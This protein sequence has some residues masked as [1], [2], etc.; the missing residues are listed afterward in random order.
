MP[1]AVAEEIALVLKSRLEAMI[2]DSS[3]YP[4]DVL[5]VIRPTRMGD[6]TPADRQVVLVQGQPEIVPELSYPGNPPATAYR[7]TY[8]IR[9]HIMGS[10]RNPEVID[11]VINQ[12][13]ADVVKAVYAGGNV[14]HTMDD[15]AIDA[16]FRSPEYVTADGGLDG[17]NV[18]I[19]ITFR[20]DEGDP[21]S[22]RA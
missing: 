3:T 18:P 20:A 9:C 6:F 10:E 8:Q 7:Q 22:V 19:A 13:H 4:T 2:G 21:T 14:W 11:T 16:E 15:N 5:E 1:L 17:V 12:F